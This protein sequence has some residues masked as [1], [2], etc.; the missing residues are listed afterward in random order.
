MKYDFWWITQRKA[1][2]LLYII[3]VAQKTPIDL[4]NSLDTSAT[5]TYTPARPRISI[6]FFL[7][8]IIFSQNTPSP[9]FPLVRVLERA[10][11][12]LYSWIRESPGPLLFLFPPDLRWREKT[13]TFSLFCA[14]PPIVLTTTARLR[15]PPFFILRVSAGTRGR[16]GLILPFTRSREN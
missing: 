16:R 2:Q 12:L 13:P 5:L 7:F 9:F 4:L 3:R 14:R 15:Q 8:I 11:A 6:G 1:A 10:K